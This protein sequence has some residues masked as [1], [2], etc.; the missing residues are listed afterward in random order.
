MSQNHESTSATP[1]SAQSRQGPV[2]DDPKRGGR[3]NGGDEERTL[4]SEAQQVASDLAGKATRSAE[5]QLAGGKERAVEVIGQFAEALR[6]SGQTIAAGTDMPMVNDYLGRAASRIE[7]LSGYLQK[8]SLT[9]MVGDVER[10][11][12]REPVLFTSGALLL[13]LLGGR[14]LRS[15]QAGDSASPNNRGHGARAGR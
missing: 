8:K 10:F 7:G 11:A 3:A 2:R 4:T 15:S 1:P 5:Q 13:G 14:F 9:D 6:H 12:R